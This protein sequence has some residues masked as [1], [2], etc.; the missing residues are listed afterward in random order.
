MQQRHGRPRPLAA[1]EHALLGSAQLQRN[2]LAARPPVLH[3][4]GAQYSGERAAA[5]TRPTQQRAA[6]RTGAPRQLLCREAGVLPCAPPRR[7]GR[8]SRMRG[9]HACLPAIA[10]AARGRSSG[11]DPQLRQPAWFATTSQSP[12]CEW[13][14]TRHERVAR[15]AAPTPAASGSEWVRFGSGHGSEGCAA[16]C[17]SGQ[18]RVAAWAVSSAAK[19]SSSPRPSRSAA[20]AAA[21]RAIGTR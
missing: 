20:W 8:P 10:T 12:R 13:R 16:I 17:R 9:R 18:R 6:G 15:P 11:L 1:N 5:A 21:M 4:H 7:P 14:C 2:Q 3:L 19:A